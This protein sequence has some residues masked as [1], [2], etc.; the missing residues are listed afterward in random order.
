MRHRASLVIDMEGMSRPAFHVARE[1]AQNS[2]SGLTTRFL[3][4]KLDLPIEEIEYLVDIHDRLFFTDITKVKLVT[5]APEAIKR[6]SRAL[7]NH[8]DVP[9]LVQGIK[10]LDSHGFRRFE[11]QVGIETPVGKKTAADEMLARHYRHPDSVV[12]YVAR[13][14]FSSM[15]RELFDIVWQ[16]DTGIMP[17]AQLRATHGG[18]EY[19]IEQGLWEL[20]RGFALFE[21]FR[22]DA[23]DRLLRAVS[24][25]N[26]L[27]QWR[28][29]A[30]ARAGAGRGLKPVKGVAGEIDARG[31]ALSDCIARLV[32]TI[33]ARPARLRSDGDLFREDRRRLSEIVPEEGDPSLGACLW[34]AQG[35]GWLARV[36]N[37]LRAA[38]VEE[39][40]SMDRA[41]RHVRVC[42]WL[43]ARGRETGSGR[44]MRSLLDDLEVGAWY[45]LMGFITEALRRNEDEEE[46]VLRCAGGHWHYT[47]P[48]GSASAR[49]GLARALEETM[50]WLGLVD[51]AESRGESVFR[52]TE[53]GAL[54]LQQRDATALRGLIP[55]HKS[56]FLVQP[57]F[58]IVVDTRAA[59]PLLTVPLDQFCERVSASQMAVY[60][61]TKDTFTRAVQQGRSS[62]AFI[63]F[64]LA[65]NKGGSLPRNVL[66]TLED[67]RGSM[68]RVRVRTVQVIE[69]DDPLVMAD[70]QHRKRIA[71]HIDPVPLDRVA[72][73][74][75]TRKSELKALLEKEGF[76]VE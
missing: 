28:M 56:E 51:R 44:L 69:A 50:L 24:L 17:V 30:E 68:K 61:L 6:V 15:A 18:S 46:P 19:D 26:E 29:D 57:N 42:E 76:V 60:H 36:D 66:T 33:G 21:L 49:R 23:E 43:L 25:L 37:E 13:R 2:R 1:L 72:V 52:V 63:E 53:I 73:L 71:K 64:L 5:E 32:A 20:F 12:E 16:S 39:L 31:A 41:A 48:S 38:N 58:D 62:G 14:G 4:K 67:W 34:T 11:E 3:A 59:D 74:K 54:V 8:G 7:E 65:H 10:A 27:R 47:T 55:P 35:V 40:V 70:V 22:F 9:S 45:P 75:K